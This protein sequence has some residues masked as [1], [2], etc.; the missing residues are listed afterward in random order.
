MN[1]H[2]ILLLLMAC[3]AGR[4]EA[5][6]TILIPF[7]SGKQ[8]GYADTTGTLKIQATYDKVEFC[9]D[10]YCQ[11]YK[12]GLT[13]FVDP[14]GSALVSILYE[15]CVP[16][17]NHINAKLNGKWGI[18]DW[19]GR[20][21]VPL[22]FDNVKWL[23]ND[24][25]QTE[26]NGAVGVQK[27]S[28]GNANTVLPVRFKSIEYVWYDHQFMCMDA[29][30]DMS[31]Y[32]ESGEPVATSASE[33]YGVIEPV[34]A[35]ESPQ[36]YSILTKKGKRFMV[37]SSQ[38]Q[39]LKNYGQILRDTIRVPYDSIHPTAHWGFILVKS[40]NKWGV[41]D[42]KGTLLLKPLFDEIDVYKSRVGNEKPIHTFYAKKKGKWGI[43]Q[44]T[45]ITGRTLPES[46][47]LVPFDYD[48]F[49]E[50]GRDF[51]IARKGNLSGVITKVSYRNITAVKY[52]KIFPEWI[53]SNN[54]FVV[55]MVNDGEME[56]VYVGENA[57]EFYKKLEI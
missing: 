20:I 32:N 31:A 7:K 37:V 36:R 18:I 52:Q 27:V 9:R 4:T 45:F 16:F 5:Q 23:S 57:R 55:F 6:K 17:Q 40:K 28:D 3:F 14:Q 49:T 26:S 19:Q 29:N 35:D 13:G 38:N 43:I 33:E 39:S 56:N 8:W 51:L 1:R 24:F 50:H 22:D 11:V 2:L 41:I 53:Y 47:I 12:D 25:L 48:S 10:G 42:D 30:G 34:S 15:A 54:D 44:N 21:V 46:K